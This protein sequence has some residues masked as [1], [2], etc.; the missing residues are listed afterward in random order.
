MAFK[1]FDIESRLDTFFYAE[2]LRPGTYTLK[3]FMHVYTDYGKLAD[4]QSASYGP[5][6]DYPYHVK[7][8]MP[9]SEEVTADLGSGVIDIFG[10]Y[11]IT[12]E[13]KDG[14]SGTTD[15]RWKV[16]EATVSIDYDADDRRAL[17]VAKNWDTANW[18]LWNVRNPEEGCR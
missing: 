14:S 11:F 18:K 10:R 9:I 13:W 17:R 2:N 5:F 8:F 1:P 12:Y 6:E 16:S 4:D 7:Q 3:G 15:D